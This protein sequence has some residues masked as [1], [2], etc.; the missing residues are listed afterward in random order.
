MS[1]AWPV[2]NNEP[3]RKTDSHHDDVVMHALAVRPNVVV[4]QDG[5]V[6]VDVSGNERV[7]EAPGGAPLVRL[8]HKPAV[9]APAQQLQLWV[10]NRIGSSSVGPGIP[11]AWE[12]VAVT[13]LGHIFDPLRP[14]SPDPP[15]QAPRLSRPFPLTFSSGQFP[16]SCRPV[17]RRRTLTQ[18]G[19][20]SNEGQSPDLS[21][22]L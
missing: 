7:P 16:D 1:H 3:W 13:Q 19:Q 15:R 4:K 14:G 11:D 17:P 8:Q 20:Q 5:D 12:P 22:V 10:E 21:D 18:E 6:I 9:E 2:C